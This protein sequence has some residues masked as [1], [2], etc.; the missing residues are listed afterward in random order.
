MRT[1]TEYIK[2]HLRYLKNAFK[3]LVNK[4][5]QFHEDYRNT[6]EGVMILVLE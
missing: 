5:G 4:N 1:K 3:K 6:E 2:V